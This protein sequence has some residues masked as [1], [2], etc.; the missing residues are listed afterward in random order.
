MFDATPVHASIGSF[1]ILKV[2]VFAIISVTV[3]YFRFVISS[4][5]RSKKARRDDTSAKRN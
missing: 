2:N 4:N 5:D 1:R 3:G